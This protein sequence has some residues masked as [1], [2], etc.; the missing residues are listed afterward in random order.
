M[1]IKLYRFILI[2]MLIGTMTLIFGFSGQ[3]GTQSKGISTKISEGILNLSSKYKE[4]E[5]K[6]QKKVLQKT[7]AVVRKIAHF[8][9]Y[10][11]LGI[12]LMGLMVKTKLQNKWRIAITLFI[13]LIYAISDEFHQIFSPGRA[14]KVTDVYIDMLGVILGALLVLLATKIYDRYMTRML[15]KKAEMSYKSY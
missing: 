11:L 9:I 8:S 13:G 6:E 2:I 10:T 7:N 15:Q 14:A 1:K 5:S 4:L 3:D 12:L